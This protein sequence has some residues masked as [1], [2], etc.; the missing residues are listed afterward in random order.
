VIVKTYRGGLHVKVNLF[1]GQ[2]PMR[3]IVIIGFAVSFL[4]TTLPAQAATSNA[5]GNTNSNRS[6]TAREPQANGAPP[7]E[8]QIC[9]REAR[10][11]SRIRR[12]VCHTAREWRDQ[13]DNDNP[14]S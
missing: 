12:P 11:E 10:S 13:Q 8:R 3:K 14:S 9:V 1:E 6:E 5:S 7:A 2:V 4:A